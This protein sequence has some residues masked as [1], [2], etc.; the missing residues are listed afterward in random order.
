MKKA[1]KYL[2]LSGILTTQKESVKE[3]YKN[4]AEPQEFIQGDWCSLLYIKK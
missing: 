1:E 2:I 3:A 4:F